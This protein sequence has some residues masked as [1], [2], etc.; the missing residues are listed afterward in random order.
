MPGVYNS[1]HNPNWKALIDSI[2]E[3]DQDVADLIESVRKQLFV[4]TASRPYIDRLGAANNIQRPKF[5]GMDD[6]TFREF[7]PIMSYNPKQVKVVLDKLL[8]L[9][10][11]KNSTTSY[12]QTSNFEPF[13]LSD[14][15]TLEYAV[16]GLNK[17]RIEFSE[18]EFQ[19]IS[20]ATANEVV[21]AINRQSKFTYAIAHEDSISRRIYIRIFTKTIGSKGSISMN[22]GL[23]NIMMQFD[24]FGRN[25]CSCKSKH[26]RK[27]NN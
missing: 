7:I 23:A 15:W 26:D 19:D 9:F 11:F 3:S 16:D 20:A 1:R 17:E 18:D 25:C 13:I 12:I 4:K 22:G 10:F 6:P 21:S 14:K 8:D 24:G 5:V 27:K 2:G